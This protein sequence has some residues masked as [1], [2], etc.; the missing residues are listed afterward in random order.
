MAD[1]VWVFD[2]DGTLMDTL[3]LYR[4]PAEEA[5][6]LIIKALGDESPSFAVIK[7]RHSELDKAMIYQ[8]DPDTNKPYLYTKKRFPTS[9]VR[10]YELLCKEAKLEPRF[11]VMRR[12]YSIGLKAFNQERYRRKIKSQA[13]L[14]FQFLKKQGDT[15]IIL[16]KGD[17]R[18]QGDKRR[19]LKKAGLLKF[20]K[21]FIIVPDDKE[22]A[23]R[24]IKT[25][26]PGDAHYTVGDTYGADIVPAIK[27]GYFGVYIP[28][29]A[30][31]MEVGKLMK[32]ERRRSKYNSN[33]Y[34]NLMEIAEKYRYL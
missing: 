8:K 25:A 29:D 10:I 14:I 13:F 2:L 17:G 15:I 26:Y 7:Q 12:L 4:K 21:A 19:A 20:V 22:P 31:W 27:C 23:F 33:H 6:M 9:F 3:D 24:G 34:S 11:S 18:V 28:S 30:N 16:T 5:Y 1:K 32:I